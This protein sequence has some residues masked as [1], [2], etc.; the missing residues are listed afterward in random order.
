MEDFSG[1]KTFVI[2]VIFEGNFTFGGKIS[3][4][5]IGEEVEIQGTRADCP[6]NNKLD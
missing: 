4:A 3:G 6:P 2:I 5:D 1:G